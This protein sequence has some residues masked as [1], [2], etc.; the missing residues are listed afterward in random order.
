[1]LV[2]IEASQFIIFLMN[3]HLLLLSLYIDVQFLMSLISAPSSIFLIS[4]YF[5]L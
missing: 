1:M 2:W 4:G 3:E 5:E